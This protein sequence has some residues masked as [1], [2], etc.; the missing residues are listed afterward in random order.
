MRSALFTFIL[1]VSVLSGIYS[2]SFDY[3]KY[4]YEWKSVKPD[5]MVLDSIYS[6]EDAVIMDEKCIYNITGNLVQNYSTVNAIGNYFYIDESSQGKSPIVQKYVRIKF[7]TQKGIDK[8]STFTLPESFDPQHDM[9]IVPHAKRISLRR[10]RGEFQCVRYFAARIIKKDGR[11]KN[12]L[13]HESTDKEIQPRDGRDITFFS[14][15]FQIGGLEPGDEL[16]IDYSYEG[17]YTYSPTSRL[18]FSGEMPK[19]NFQLTFRQRQKDTYFIFDHNVSNPADTFEMAGSNMRYRDVIYKEK[20]LKGGISECGSRPARELPYISF[21][22][23]NLDFGAHQANAAVIQ[24]PLPYPWWFKLSP[25]LSYQYDDLNFKL[26][27][28]DKTTSAMNKFVEEERSK[29]KDTTTAA[30]ISGIHHT[31][32]E[33]FDYDDDINYYEGNDTKLEKLGKNVENKLL[34]QISRHHF[35]EQIFLRLDREYYLSIMADKRTNS[36]DPGKY[37]HLGLQSWMYSVPYKDQFLFFYPKAS[38]F[39]Y[40]AN[41]FP[42]YYENVMTVLVPQHLPA[43]NKSDFMPSV[44]FKFVRTPSSNHEDNNRQTTAIISASLDSLNI[45]ISGKLKLSGQFSTLTRGYYL[46]QSMDTTINPVYYK[47]IKD[48]ADPGDQVQISSEKLSVLFPFPATFAFNFKKEKF[49]QKA[50]D[51]IYT[52]GFEGWFNNFK[53]EEFSSENRRL[54]YYPDFK[55]EDIHRFLMQFDHPVKLLEAENMVDT[56]SNSYGY[57]II[58][59]EQKDDYKLLFET[60]L[61]V[62]AEMVPAS[63]AA[64]IQSIFDAITSLNQ[65]KFKVKKI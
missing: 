35:Y 3:R 41:E 25:F 58:K 6:K 19:Q 13:L 47:S 65:R 57:Y 54:D 2:Q 23:H 9:L 50:E 12:A 26:K 31:I 59:I 7:L 38:R 49:I 10:P 46:Y 60:S 8:F 45:R 36:I 24:Y 14:W 20:N 29:V 44:E 48:L 40:E 33:S 62:R 11:I 28:K 53:D 32:V 42:F 4:N 34:R 5:P 30:I 27:W 64:D 15:N 52:F 61:V 18:F 39:G 37:E 51:G 56:F 16:E 22:L 55:S 17:S 63:K 1:I 21:Y 43:E